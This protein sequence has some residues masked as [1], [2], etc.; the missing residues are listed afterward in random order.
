MELKETTKLMV[1]GCGEEMKFLKNGKNIKVMIIS[2]L[3]K[4]IQRMKLIKNLPKNI[5]LT[6]NKDN[7]LKE[8]QSLMPNGSNESLDVLVNL[9]SNNF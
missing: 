2:L 4:W 9:F 6:P 1:F 8:D 3:L 7:L 5:G